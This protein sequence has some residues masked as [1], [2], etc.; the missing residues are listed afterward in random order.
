MSTQFEQDQQRWQQDRDETTPAAALPPVREHP[1]LAASFSEYWH[2]KWPHQTRDVKRLEKSAHYAGCQ[3]A[4]LEGARAAFL[5][6][7][8]VETDGY[9][10][11]ASRLADKWLNESWGDGK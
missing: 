3:E 9:V 2:R 6:R 11:G 7:A 5:L 10:G 4:F 8:M 1:L